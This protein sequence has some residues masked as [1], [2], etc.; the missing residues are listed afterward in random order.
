L[1]SSNI[2]EYGNGRQIYEKFVQPAK[3]DL[4]E[5]GAHYSISSLF[6]DYAPEDRIFC[7]SI[8]QEDYRLSE[9]GKA[10]L[11][12]GRIRVTSEITRH[13]SD[14]SFSVLHFGD[15][16]MCGGVR[17]YLGEEAYNVMAWEVTE[18]F[19]WAEFPETIRRID[20]HFGAST[21]SLRSLFRDEQRKV[22]DQIMDSSIEEARAAY[23]LIYNHHVPLMRFLMDLNV[24]LPKAYQATAEFVLNLNLRQAFEADVLDPVY[25]HNLLEEA[26]VMH[27]DLDGPSME[28]ALRQTLERLAENFRDQ[29][30]ELPFLQALND[31]LALAADLP[32][33]V[34]LWKVQNIY[35]EQLHTI[36]P[37]WRRQASQGQAQAQTWIEPFV[38]LGEKLMIH[39]D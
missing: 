12:V 29:P 3:V 25:I 7:F 10:K 30:T 16:N 4:L 18:A 34:N 1:A 24:P 39:V 15:H 6:E 20:H 38:A 37:Q 35:Y 33:E 26:R 28:Y 21:Y 2:P 32:F 23:R 19:S 8:K 31:G 11:A 14:L 9:V 36:Y 22:L 17:N 27:V 13:A 5:V